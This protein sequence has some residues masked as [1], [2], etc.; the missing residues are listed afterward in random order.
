MKTS[1]LVSYYM[2]Y[3]HYGEHIQYNSLSYEICHTV[4]V[5]FMIMLL[6]LAAN[7]KSIKAKSIEH[8]DIMMIHQIFFAQQMLQPPKNSNN[9]INFSN[10]VQH[11]K[12]LHYFRI[13]DESLGAS[14]SLYGTCVLLT[15]LRLSDLPSF[16]L[17]NH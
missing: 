16:D 4:D 12:W 17:F 1:T 15:I 8:H 6:L 7:Y 14:S 2:S 10:L 5:D 11:L 9:Q 13:F 3:F